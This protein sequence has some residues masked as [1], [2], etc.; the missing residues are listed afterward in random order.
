M[1]PKSIS[2]SSETF[3]RF[4]AIGVFVVGLYLLRSIAVLVLVSIV[5]ASFVEAGVRFFNKKNIGRSLSVPLIYCV[6]IL[7]LFILLW[8]FLPIV[9]RELEGVISLIL[10]YLGGSGQNTKVFQNASD[11]VTQFS[12]QEGSFAEILGRAQSVVSSISGG[13][14]SIVGSTFGGVLNAV[15]VIVM[16]FYLSIQEK[17]ID[18]FLKIITPRKHEEY[19][20]NLWSRTQVKI[21]LWFQGQMF[22][23]LIMGVI[24]FI[25]LVI[26]GVQNALLIAI[27][28]GIF[29]LIPFGLTFAAVPAILFAI[30]DGG[31]ILGVKVLIFFIIIQQLENY[32]FQPM[33]VKR[34]VGIPPLVVLLSLLIG[35]SL[36]GFW[37]AILALPVAVLV[38]EYLSDME[39]SKEIITVTEK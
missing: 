13:F 22:L 25:G 17:G 3:V 10:E 21:G 35:I 32:L 39:K 19:V 12:S 31:F 16:S 30:L 24:V 14:T 26:M 20:L 9:F 33:V 36:A 27:I 37:G 7:A 15:L 5:I 6:G 4:I 1:E 34:V 29:E 23:G 11:L 38:L 28:S 8:A 18:Q 2:I